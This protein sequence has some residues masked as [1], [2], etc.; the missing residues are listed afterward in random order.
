M[1]SVE[2]NNIATKIYKTLIIKQVF[3][4]EYY[5]SNQ[6]IINISLSQTKNINWKKRQQ[7]RQ[8]NGNKIKL[9]SIVAVYQSLILDKKIWHQ[10][11]YRQIYH[12]GIIL[13]YLIA[14]LVAIII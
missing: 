13:F 7:K 2:L 6:Y 9:V 5:Y 12:S 4:I 8:Q 1:S 14:I 10:Q 11:L 3:Q